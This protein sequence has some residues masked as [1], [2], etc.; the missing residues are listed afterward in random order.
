[1]ARARRPVW[2]PDAFRLALAVGLLFTAL[3]L[4]NGATLGRRFELPVLARIEH[5]AQDWALTS[6]RGPRAP[7]GRVVVVA[8]DERSVREEG[9]W[10]WSRAKMARLVDRLAEGG[11]AAAG[12]D[13]AWSEGDELGRRM[14]R[15]AALLRDAR[16]EAGDGALA[17]RLDDAWAAA[18]GPRPEGAADA[19]PTRLLADAIERARNVTVGFMLLSGRDAPV[20]AAARAA[21][22]ERL[23]FLRAEP[24]H[25]R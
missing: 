5:A 4:L 2:K 19:D 15:V 12:F 13:V 23:R 7:T 10:P 11:V 8:I 3:H 17:R 1:M 25:V 6:L 18:Q 9:L 16:A 20:E 22:V 24:V 21:A 14:A